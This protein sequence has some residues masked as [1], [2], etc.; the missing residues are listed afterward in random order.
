MT[1]RLPSHL[2]KTVPPFPLDSP[3][4]NGSAAVPLLAKGKGKEVMIDLTT[5]DGE[6]EDDDDDDDEAKVIED[7]EI[8]IDETPI[9]I[10]L[11][12]SLALVLYPISE[13]QSTPARAGVPPQLTIPVHIYRT[14]MAAPTKAS[15]RQ[16]ESLK[17]YATSCD[18][19]SRKPQNTQFAVMEK[20]VANA[21]GPLLGEGWSGTGWSEANSKSTATKMWCEAAV[22]RRDER[23]VSCCCSLLFLKLLYMY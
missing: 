10:G 7:D 11:L 3:L 6:G 19:A 1:A 15:D 8:I 12:A 4:S 2:V 13:L 17:I 21:I 23:N 16:N 18:N 14:P 22:V 5:S 20:K 9:C